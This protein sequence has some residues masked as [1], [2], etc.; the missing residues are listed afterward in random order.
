MRYFSGLFF[1]FFFFKTRG[2]GGRGRRRR[3]GIG[4]TFE[5]IPIPATILDDLNSGNPD[6][7]FRVILE[8]KRGKE[9]LER[10][11]YVSGTGSVALARLADAVL[12]QAAGDGLLAA[13][14]VLG[15]AMLPLGSAALQ[16]GR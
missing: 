12:D 1:L 11:S 2:G 5:P 9:I 14:Q 10:D 15:C 7:I 4:R 13:L 3:R 8:S 6:Q 16:R